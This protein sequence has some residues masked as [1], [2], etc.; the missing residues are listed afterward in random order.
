MQPL[1]ILVIVGTRPEAIKLAPVML[2]M[3]LRVTML[4]LVLPLLLPMLLNDCFTRLGVIVL[5]TKRMLLLELVR[6]ALA[7][8]LALVM[9]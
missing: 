1:H 5:G 8:I 2:A 3:I 6:I 9:R 4:V 7:R